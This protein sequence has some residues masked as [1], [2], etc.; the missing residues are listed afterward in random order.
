[1]TYP[2]SEQDMRSY[3]NA[4][5]VHLP[6]GPMYESMLQVAQEEP[7]RAFE[8][9]VAYY[10]GD[11][12]T[13]SDIRSFFYAMA[14]GESWNQRVD[15]PTSGTLAEQTGRIEVPVLPDE[16]VDLCRTRFMPMVS[17]HSTAPDVSVVEFVQT[18][19][20]LGIAGSLAEDAP[21]DE[22]APE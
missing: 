5:I 17:E 9:L 4:L 3:N 13:R 1:M 20:D 12:G 22:D 11:E 21:D 6:R 2:I 14:D 18:L 16:L 8:A 10:N 7:Q 19:D 15:G